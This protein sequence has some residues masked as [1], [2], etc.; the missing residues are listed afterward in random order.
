MTDE[1]GSLAET[2]SG[3]ARAPSDPR[4]SCRIGRVASRN[5][6]CALERPRTVRN[7]VRACFLPVM[8]QTW[9][10]FAPLVDSL[11]TRPNRSRCAHPTALSPSPCPHP[12]WSRSFSRRRVGWCC[13]AVRSS[14]LCSIRPAARWLRPPRPLPCAALCGARTAATSRCCPRI[15]CGCATAR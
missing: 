4:R 6:I 14:S 8:V 3:R 15:W 11:L 5:R 9:L 1:E 2:F 12:P 7:V 13:T 10:Y